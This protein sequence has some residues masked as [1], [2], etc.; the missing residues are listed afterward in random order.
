MLEEVVIIDPE[1]IASEIAKLGLDLEKLIE[2]VRYADNEGALCTRNDP[3]GYRLI[4]VNAKAARGLREQFCGDEW[5]HDEAGNQP[6]ILNERLSL[7]II[8]CNFD[9]NAGNPLLTPTNW[10]EKGTA[11]GRK[12]RCNGTGWLPGL[13]S[14]IIETE[15][16]IVTLVLGIYSQDGEPLSAELS[17]PI[18]F[19]GG[20]YT[21]FSKR[22]VVLNSDSDNGTPIDDSDMGGPTEIVEIDVKRK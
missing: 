4:T 9:E 20:K 1:T 11:S 22:I 17:Y 5:V 13:D 10:T 6:G 2:V 15:D 7:R 19:S 21:K 18:D 12:V 3:K 14:P 8:P 16:E